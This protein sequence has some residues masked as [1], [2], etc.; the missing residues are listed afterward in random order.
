[1]LTLF[2]GESY[3]RTLCINGQ[4]RGERPSPYEA[5][6]LPLKPGECEISYLNDQGYLENLIFDGAAYICN[7]DGKTVQKIDVGGFVANLPLTEAA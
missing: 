6:R 7:N 1:M 3:D 5:I 2:Y 4:S